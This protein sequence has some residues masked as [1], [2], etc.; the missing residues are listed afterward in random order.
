M[1]TGCTDPGRWGS[2]PGLDADE[3]TVARYVAHLDECEF[4]ARG[5]REAEERLTAAG[6]IGRARVKGGAL[7]LPG[8]VAERMRGRNEARL[9]AVG[10]APATEISVRVDGVEK[11]RVSGERDGS[12][13]VAAPVGSLVTAWS[14]GDSAGDLFLTSC[15][16]SGDGVSE[17][18]SVL[19]KGRTIAFR[20]E[21]R[22]GG[23]ASVRV[24]CANERRA[25]ASAFGRLVGALAGTSGRWAPAYGLAAAALAIAVM[26][27]FYA[28]LLADEPPESVE[29]QLPPTAAPPVDEIWEPVPPGRAYDRAYTHPA[30]HAAPGSRDAT[31]RP[32]PGAPVTD[33]AD[34][35]RIYIAADEAS[36]EFGKA[37]AAALEA[38][39]AYD[40]VADERSADAT[41]T[42]SATRG[43]KI[44]TALSSADGPLW[45]GPAF[46]VSGARSSSE[47]AASLVKS[48]V[49]EAAKARQKRPD[50]DPPRP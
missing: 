27:P 26:A 30:P 38:E 4:H 1:A 41:L 3:E 50:A 16:V 11:A 14:V 7:V 46:E 25:D 9:A 34:V 45:F 23:L 33:L 49:D 21:S 17:S 8:V 12:V 13:A 37:L 29:L 32:K 28:I 20:V 40:V 15:V 18:K 36:S 43:A 48:L 22:S 35:R 44:A 31:R 39:G 5:E 10:R 2:A 19:A 47:A 42:L 24:T 6:A